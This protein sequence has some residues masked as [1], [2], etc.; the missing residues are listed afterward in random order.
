MFRWVAITLI[1]AYQMTL[2]QLF[3]PSCR[4][5]PTCSNYAIGV[6]QRF[7]L[8]RG[9]ILTLKRLVKCHPGHPG[10][11]DPVPDASPGRERVESI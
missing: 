2:S 6:I 3:P 1:R 4:F 10:G 8:I 7:G 5:T 11:Y 9:T